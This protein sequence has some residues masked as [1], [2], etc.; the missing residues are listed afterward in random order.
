MSERSRSF[1]KQLKEVMLRD[2]DMISLIDHIKHN[3]RIVED[4]KDQFP[5]MNKKILKISDDEME[6]LNDDALFLLERRL[7]DPKIFNKTL[8]ISPEILIMECSKNKERWDIYIIYKILIILYEKYLNDEILREI[9]ELSNMFE[10]FKD[11]RLPSYKENYKKKIYN[12]FREEMLEEYGERL[13]DMDNK[14]GNGSA[15]FKKIEYSISFI[16]FLKNKNSE[17]EYPIIDMARKYIRE[18]GNIDK[19]EYDGIFNYILNELQKE[20]E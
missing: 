13:K 1:L 9:I 16:N 3:K 4:L 12:V 2:C 15:K 6:S 10:R 11:L 17:I 5:I 14:F 7:T 8:N 19:I 20:I 18:N